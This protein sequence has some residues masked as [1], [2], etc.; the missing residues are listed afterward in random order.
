[1]SSVAGRLRMNMGRSA[2]DGN[3]A[4]PAA[5]DTRSESS[6]AASFGVAGSSADATLDPTYEFDPTHETVTPNRRAALPAMPQDE[7]YDSSADHLRDELSRI[8]CLLQ[9]QIEIWHETLAAY[10]THEQ[11]ALPIITSGEIAAYLEMPY[12]RRAPLSEATQQRVARLK[13]ASWKLGQAIAGRVSVTPPQTRLRLVDLAARFHLSRLEYDALLVCLL[14][15]D[16]PR[17][18]RII[19]YLL[20]DGSRTQ[21]TVALIQEILSAANEPAGRRLFDSESSLIHWR[22]VVLG[23][24]ARES[25]ALSNRSVRIDNRI[26]GYLYESDAMA[27]DV[28]D[29]LAPHSPEG[30]TAQQILLRPE[31]SR[32]LESLAVWWDQLRTQVCGAAL[33]LHGPYGVG[34][35]TAARLICDATET[36]LLMVD[37]RA[38]LRQPSWIDT[39]RM[40]Y[41]E[42]TLL[43]AAICWA[44]VDPLVLA[45]DEDKRQ[46]L[47]VLLGAAEVYPG[48]TFL[49]GPSPFDPAG[50]FRRIPFLSIGLSPPDF[51]ERLDLW[52]FLLPPDE[53]FEDGELDG[54]PLAGVLANGFQLT[55]GQMHDAIATARWIS[56]KRNPLDPALRRDD[57]AEGC[58][59]QSGRNLIAFSTRIEARS[60][61][62][63][64][65]LVLPAANKRQLQELRNRFA[66]QAQVRSIFEQR[67]TLGQG[68]I[69]LFT[70][71][72]GTGK[73]MAAQLLARDQG[74]DL[75]KIDLSAVVSKWVGETEKN[76][77]RV[78]TEAADANAILFFDEADALFGQ[79]AKVEQAQDRWANMEVNFLLQRVEEYAGIVILASNLRQ[80]IDDAF[81]RRIQVIVDFPFPE[82]DARFQIIRGMIPAEV[83]APDD[84]VLRE[85]AERFKL[86]GGS[87]KNIVVDA[88]FRATVTPN[89]QPIVTDRHLILAIAR[90]YQKLGKPLMRGEF[91]EAY[92]RVIEQEI[93]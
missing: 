25:D 49:I 76:L 87:W 30:A 85:L 44:G 63:F 10:K 79:R 89:L 16:Q 5:S 9:A 71:G 57:L 33:Y 42:A 27:Q 64:G 29:I 46:Q 18:R 38:A 47:D 61:L 26:A 62:D 90:E 84:A 23:E 52:Q 37:V 69:A 11:L 81:V 75:Y 14:A 19:G 39:I 55:P 56:T 70:G 60:G 68:M 32:Q 15:E 73:T 40:C 78:F 59:R 35:R 22:L 83:H 13:N 67:L 72:S 12:D 6:T 34:R 74:L 8:D 17:Y 53:V 93:L 66:R 24:E 31:D 36:P 41:R 45:E 50:R 82:A 88:T 43:N 92:F 3:S 7:P 91:G 28:L 48:L 80:N 77:N 20:D 21:P 1:M 2:A 58:R 86:P 54:P 51:A 4:S 65:D